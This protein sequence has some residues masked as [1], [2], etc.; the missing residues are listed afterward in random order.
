MP[1]QRPPTIGVDIASIERVAGALERTPG[2]RDRVFTAAEQADC[3]DR[4]DRWAGR[5]AAKEAVRKLWGAAGVRP[6]PAFRD[7]EIVRA[8]GGEPLVR[9]RGEEAAIA[10]SM[11]HDAGVAVAVALGLA[12]DPLDAPPAGGLPTVGLALPE[13]SPDA[14]KGTFGTVVVVAGSHGFSGA[15]YLAAMG[16]ARAGAGRVRLCVPAELHPAMAVKCVEVMPHPLPD[17][18][19]GI[20]GAAALARLRTEHLPAAQALVVG[21]GIGLDAETGEALAGLL[22]ELPCPAVVDADA[23]TLAGRLGFDWRRAAQAVVLTPHP[24][25]M[26]RLL[27]AGADA[28]GVQRE[29]RTVAAGY[30]RERGAVVVLKGAGTLVAAPDGRQ[31][32]APYALPALATGGT[33]DVLSGI[34]GAFLAAG[35]PAFEAAVAAVTVHGEAGAELQALRGRAGALASDLLEQL[36]MAQERLRRALERGRAGLRD[37]KRMGM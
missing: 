13:R 31:W 18:G 25:E 32:E 20:I 15:A 12:G 5:W 2:L 22:V 1:D 30:A 24:A 9:C 21:P 14:H 19:R 4:P 36:P 8:A 26:A 35:I 33:G 17:A 7:I 10:L 28:G 23:L 27:G 6:L 34:C 29:R 16:A 11:T 3:A 37:T